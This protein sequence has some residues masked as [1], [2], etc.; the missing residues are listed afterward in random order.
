MQVAVDLQQGGGDPFEEDA[1]VGDGDGGAA[2]AAQMVFE[3]GEGGVVEVVGRFVEQQDPGCGGQQGGQAQADLFAAG[4]AGDGAVAGQAHQAEAVQ[5]AFE[6][7]VGLVAPA[8]LE[9][10]EQ[11]G[12]GAEHGGGVVA[13][14]GHPR[15]QEAH[16][17]LHGAQ[18]V[19]RA[20]DHL[21]DGEVRRELLLLGQVADA[22]VSP[23][24]D[25]PLVWALR[26][27]EEPEQRGLS[28]SVLADDAEPGAG[29]DRAGDVGEDEAAVVGLADV[30]GGE[31]CSH[32]ATPGGDR[33][34][35]R[36]GG[37]AGRCGGGCGR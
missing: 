7:G 4:E 18:F 10:G 31:L 11:V 32:G 29:R 30:K 35:G 22:S 26:A 19:Q 6:A 8:E 9:G 14:V 12:V 16:L 17:L 13:R 34:G 15:F 20:V 28:G 23:G 2:S 21:L 33:G 1:V 37:G 24:D 3:P 36:G 25:L 27:G 5:G